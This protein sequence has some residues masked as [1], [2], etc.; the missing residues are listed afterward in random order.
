MVVEVEH[1]ASVRVGRIDPL[2]AAEEPVAG[3]AARTERLGDYEVSFDGSVNLDN[4][5]R[6]L[7]LFR[8][9]L[10][11][12]TEL[13]PQLLSMILLNSAR[14]ILRMERRLVGLV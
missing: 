12:R 13:M 9:F 6:S 4:G 1:G 2:A 10:L 11:I 3:V 5:A 7:Y 14:V 8:C